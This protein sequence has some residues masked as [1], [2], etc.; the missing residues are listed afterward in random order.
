MALV[1]S[2]IATFVA[3]VGLFV[4]ACIAGDH[5]AARAAVGDA[6]GPL[7]GTSAD[8]AAILA[9]QNLAP[10]DV[11]AGEITVTNVG[12][13]AGAFALGSEATAD[14]GA[15]LAHELDLAVEDVTPGRA[16]AVVFTGR[17]ADLSNVALGSMTQG[18]AHRYRFT[19]SL[20]RAAGN[21]YQGASTAVTLVWR[22][23]GPSSTTPTAPAATPAPAAAAAAPAPCARVGVTAHVRV[24]GARVGVHLAG[25]RVHLAARVGV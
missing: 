12:D 19:V 8:G 10:G 5:G 22:A 4:A 18:E 11:R 3:A 9:A 25:V 17:L 1:R 20:P 23:T 14:S 21:A 24:L 6:T 2:R 16:R 15:G 7:V 13:Q